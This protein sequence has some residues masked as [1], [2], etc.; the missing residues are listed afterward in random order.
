MVVDYEKPMFEIYRDILAH[1]HKSENRQGQISAMSL[2]LPRFSQ[3]VQRSLG[4]PFPTCTI[5]KDTGV[6]D[7]AGTGDL[8]FR[9]VGFI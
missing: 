9:V 4:G 2:L 6:R 1:T 7:K 5:P 8:I 3:L